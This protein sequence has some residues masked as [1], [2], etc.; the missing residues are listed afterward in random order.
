MMRQLICG[1]LLLLDVLPGLAQAAPASAAHA[2]VVQFILYASPVSN[3]QLAARGF[4]LREHVNRWRDL[5]RARGERYTIVTS[6]ERL[7]ELPVPASLILPSAVALDARERAVILDRLRRGDHL[8]ATAFPGLYD[9]TGANRGSEFLA[10]LLPVTLAAEVANG[11]QF[12]VT[13]ASSPLAGAVSPT[14][15]LW[16]EERLLPLMPALASPADAY[17][18]DWSRSGNRGVMAHA[19]VGPSRRLLLGWP[20]EAWSGQPAEFAALAQRAI[21]W[22][23]NRPLVHVAAWPRPYCAALT[24]GVDATW[25][26]ENVAPVAAALAQRQVRGTFNFLLADL[27]PQA[28]LIG[29]LVADG[30]SIGSL[31]DRWEPFAG[32][33]EDEQQRRIQRLAPA[34]AGLVAGLR[35]PEGRSDAV[36][37]RVARQFGYL[38]DAGRVDAALPLPA[39][40]ERPVL[41]ANGHNFDGTLSADQ[42]AA[43]LRQL[44][45]TLTRVGGYTYVGL[46][47]ANLPPGGALWNGM[48]DFLDVPETHRYLWI[49]AAAAI[50][51]WTMATTRLAAHV[52]AE[53]PNW[54]LRV[55]VANGPALPPGMSVLVASPAGRQLA[56]LVGE[57]QVRLAAADDG[58]FA[59]DLSG[60]TPGAYLWHLQLAP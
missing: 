51:A 10:A 3:R 5:L 29:A 40:A 37:E 41:L 17:L 1:L 12:L 27:Q 28:A 22:V 43:T 21:D 47:A 20:E 25:R 11:G 2:E 59:V 6:V 4:S 23:A 58:L 36:T 60:L 49:D 48:A 39:T 55:D 32:Q 46:D 18:S 31:G 38:V 24:L 19:T 9:D 16:L 14:T 53:G 13:A 15:R 54:R 34:G 57:P 45:A 8:L 42:V 50:A 7:A 35:V 26:F 44:A 56:G 30:H 52:E 33:S